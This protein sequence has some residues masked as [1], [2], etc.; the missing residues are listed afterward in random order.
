[1]L[2]KI[3]SNS[4]IIHQNFNKLSILTKK[5]KNRGLENNLYLAKTKRNLWTGIPSKDEN[6]KETCRSTL[7]AQFPQLFTITGMH[8]I[9]TKNC[10]P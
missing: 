7:R 4:I 2:Q 10:I 9:N 1:M 3:A 6:I 5:D 8:R